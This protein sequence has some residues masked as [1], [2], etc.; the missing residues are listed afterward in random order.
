MPRRIILLSDGTGNSSASFWRTNVWRMSSA[1]DLTSNDQVA[2]YDDG[3]RRCVSGAIDTRG[4]ADSAGAGASERCRFDRP[5]IA[6]W[7]LDGKLSLTWP[8]GLFGV[9][10]L[11]KMYAP[12]G[13]LPAERLDVLSKH[14][15][16]I[17]APFSRP[18]IHHIQRFIHLLLLRPFSRMLLFA[19]IHECSNERLHGLTAVELN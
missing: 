2:C 16:L 18:T 8:F 9:R 13:E 3:V 14:R 4:T 19:G 7:H 5:H 11:S 15:Q 1:L 12:L 10:N 6:T 17:R